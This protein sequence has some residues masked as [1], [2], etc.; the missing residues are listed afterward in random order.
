MRAPCRGVHV[1]GYVRGGG[2]VR[3]T[4]ASVVAQTETPLSS[5]PISDGS[6]YR[7]FHFADGQGGAESRRFARPPR[8]TQRHRPSLAGCPWEAAA[9]GYLG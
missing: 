3:N 7:R 2:R 9:A 6:R 4:E 5:L 1:R 8:G